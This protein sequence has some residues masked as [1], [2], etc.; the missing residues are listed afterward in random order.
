VIELFGETEDGGGF[1]GGEL[2]GDGIVLVRAFAV[3][4]GTVVVEADL[5][6]GGDAAGEGFRVEEPGG[7]LGGEGEEEE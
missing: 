2:E 4:D 5:G 7:I 1:G 3:F 6:V